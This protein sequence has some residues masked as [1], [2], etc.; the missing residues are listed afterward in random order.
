LLANLHT[1]GVELVSDTPLICAML[2]QVCQTAP[3]ATVKL[4]QP[5]SDVSTRR[6]QPG[7]HTRAVSGTA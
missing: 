3:C 6:R 2:E 4:E 7:Q 5:R 1:E